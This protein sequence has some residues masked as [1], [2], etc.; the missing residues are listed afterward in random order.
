[1]STEAKVLEYGSRSTRV[2]SFRTPSFVQYLLVKIGHVIFAPILTVVSIY[3]DRGR[4]VLYKVI[5]GISRTSYFTTEVRKMSGIPKKK[6]TI[7]SSFIT[8]IL[9]VPN[10]IQ[11]EMRQEATIL[12]CRSKHGLNEREPS[13][14]WLRQVAMEVHTVSRI[15]TFSFQYLIHKG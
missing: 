4:T 5:F 6:T 10:S 14:L 1:M 11:L 15:L 3:R 9:I 8:L 13:V 7:F 2:R 12:F